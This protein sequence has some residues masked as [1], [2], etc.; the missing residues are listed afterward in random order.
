VDPD[1]RKTV[2][3]TNADGSVKRVVTN[4]DGSKLIIVTDADGVTTITHEAPYESDRY[5]ATE[6]KDGSTTVTLPDGTTI[7]VSADKKTVTRVD[8]DG[9]TTVTTTD[10]DGSKTVVTRPDG[11]KATL[12]AVAVAPTPAPTARVR[13]AHRHTPTFTSDHS[14][15]DHHQRRWKHH[16]CVQQRERGDGERGRQH[17]D[18]YRR[19]YWQDDSSDGE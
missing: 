14:R 12:H 16:H 4:V 1:G 17:S 6:N 10:A 7:S 18:V 11:S 13:V 15:Y 8:P 5:E 19:H 2:V 9:T 3:T